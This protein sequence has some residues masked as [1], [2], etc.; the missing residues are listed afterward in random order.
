MKKKIVFLIISLI[1]VGVFVFRNEL[2]VFYLR[3]SLK[4][5]QI[6]E[7]LTNLVEEQV[8]VKISLPP[9]LRS[10]LS[11]EE[12]EVFLTR[13]GI[14]S[15]TNMQREKFGLPPLKE[16]KTLDAMAQ[17]KVKDMFENHYFAHESPSGVEVDGLARDFGYKFIALGEN[18]ALGNFENDPVLIQGWMDSPGHRANI[19]NEG[20]DEIGVGA[21]KGVFEGRTTWLAV[22][23]FGLPLS[24]CPEP[25]A[26][27]KLKIAGNQ[28]QLAIFEKTL[29]QLENALKITPRRGPDYI[30]KIKDYNE[31]VSK[32]NDFLEETK[33]LIAQY[34]GLVQIFND[35]ANRLE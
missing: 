9:P 18:L 15:Q 16:N 29:N 17:T 31:F 14:I 13:E 3:L 10:A 19:L 33:G 23:H 22:Q 26:A 25:S 1:L 30:Q 7:E 6:E 24:A 28:E 2:T 35:C 11:R 5:P 8:G 34:N 4:L 32:Y 12:K 27:L 20:Y 21:A